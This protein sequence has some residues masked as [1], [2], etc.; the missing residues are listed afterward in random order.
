MTNLIQRGFQRSRNANLMGMALL[1]VL[2][3][4]LILSVVVGIRG[5]GAA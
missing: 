3:V 5:L 2:T 4:V 1:L